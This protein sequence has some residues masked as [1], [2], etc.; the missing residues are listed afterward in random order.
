MMKFGSVRATLLPQTHISE[1][2]ETNCKYVFRRVRLRR[3]Q[4]CQQNELPFPREMEKNFLPLLAV[5]LVRVC[6]CVCTLQP[7]RGD[8]PGM[9]KPISLSGSCRNELLTTNEPAKHP[10]PFKVSCNESRGSRCTF[11][12]F[13]RVPLVHAAP[14]VGLVLWPVLDITSNPLQLHAEMFV[15]GWYAVYRTLVQCETDSARRTTGWSRRCHCANQ[16]AAHELVF[17]RSTLNHFN[18]SK[19]GFRSN[20]DPIPGLSGSFNSVHWFPFLGSILD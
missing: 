17:R 16:V 20:S 3:R 12:C 10:F 5:R 11:G 7:R 8:T 15:Y 14:S 6:G 9:T 18:R 4:R 1:V 19:F 13:S 2:T